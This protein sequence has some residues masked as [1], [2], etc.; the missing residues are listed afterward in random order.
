MIIKISKDKIK[1]Y[2]GK[3]ISLAFR[4]RNFFENNFSFYNFR[5][6]ILKENDPY[7]LYPLDTNIENICLPE[8]D[9]KKE[10]IYYCYAL[11]SNNFREFN[12]KFLVSTSNQNDN[13]NISLYKNYIEEENIDKKYYK[14]DI[15]YY[16]H[17]LNLILFKFE[18]EDNKPKIILSSYSNDKDLNYPQIYSP[19]IYRL[20]NTNKVFNFNL[21]NRDCLLIFKLIYGRGIIIFDNYPKIDINENYLGKQI[22]IPFSEVKNITFQSYKEED[23]IFY[24]KLEYV[25]QQFEM[26]EIFY[27]E[28]MNEILLNTKFPIFYYIKCDGQDNIDINFRI[29]NIEDINTST[30]ITI[31]GYMINQT[32]FKRR[33]NGEFIE[34]KESIQGQYDKIFKNGI[35]Q[36]N[37]TIIN[38]YINNYKGDNGNETMNYALIVIDGGHFISNSLSIEIIAMSRNNDNY[39]VPVNQYIMGYNASNNINYLIKNYSIDNYT[40][41]IIEF[42]PNYQDIK[43]NFDK[44]TNFLT[45]QEDII[46]GI[47]KYRINTKNKEIILNINKSEGILNGNYLFRYYYLKNKEEFQYKFDISSYSK[48][49]M[50]D[51]YNKADICLEFNKFEIYF[52]DAL[53]SNNIPYINENEIKNGIRLKIYGFLYKKENT[54]NEYNEMLNTSAF[55]SSEFSYKNNTEI[56]YTTNNK[57][58]ICFNNMDKA[59]YFYDMQIKINIIFNDYFF[60]EDSLVSTLFINLKDEFA[61]NGPKNSIFLIFIIII[62]IAII[63]LL[64]ILF[65]NFK[66]K[67]KNKKLEN[68]VLSISLSSLNDNQ[69]FDK[70]SE[71]KVDPDYDNAFI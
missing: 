20:F 43:L 25:S 55:I 23:F 69:L 62:I 49:I 26:K 13:Y 53:V 71:K 56:S 50:N 18:F 11:L 2:I 31:N 17:K 63:V 51:K 46:N 66:L 22:T 10:N 34:L 7:L 38:K 35:L 59:N 64:V 54:N 32:T 24:I 16:Y 14:T 67:K 3:E 29:I 15:Y 6:L 40:D 36:I 65:Y 60:K 48:K 70:D 47:Q 33:L 68:K 8:K 37:E 27:D 45:Y 19:K 5:I 44:S 52:N 9:K 28:S 61:K 1:D 12:L 41:I 39:L 4:S 30:D 21:T 58:K 57:F 42:S